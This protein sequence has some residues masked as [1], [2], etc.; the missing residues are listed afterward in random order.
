MFS[1]LQQNSL[2][3]ILDKTDGTKFKVGK[4]E[5]ISAPQTNY[6]LGTS[7]INIKVNVDGNIHEYNQIPSNLE[8]VSYNNNR[9]TLSETKQG[10]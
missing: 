7:Y 9:I 5:S 3:Y 6:N 8:S 1:A 4:V 2:V 10:L